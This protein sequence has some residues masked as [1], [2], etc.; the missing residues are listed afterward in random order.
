M[1]NFLSSQKQY[2]FSYSFLLSLISSYVSLF[3]HG[4][5]PH[6]SPFYY[7]LSPVMI[8]FTCECAFI[9][10]LFSSV[11]LSSSFNS[12]SL[13]YPPYQDDILTNPQTAVPSSIELHQ[14]VIPWTYDYTV[15]K[16]WPHSKVIH[17][18]Q[19]WM[20][21]LWNVTCFCS[22]ML[23]PTFLWNVLGFFKF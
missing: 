7:L 12:S 15:F 11:P 3:F 14:G 23:P 13:S 8:I 19:D 21:P 1:I 18:T 2:L 6:L 5:P 16:M 17:L 22:C 4:V 20:N 9:L 10:Y